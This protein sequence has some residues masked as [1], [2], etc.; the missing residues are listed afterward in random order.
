VD[1]WPEIVRT[2]GPAAYRAAWRILGQQQDCEDV[3]QEAFVEAFTKFET[4]EVVHWQSFLNRLVTFRAIDSMR[5]RRRTDNVHEN[6]VLDPAPGP[7]ATVIDGEQD[8]IFRQCVAALPDRQAAV[9]CMVHFEGVS[10]QQIAE[11]LEITTGAVAMALHKARANLQQK[12]IPKLE[13]S[14]ND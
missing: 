11:T 1:R 7:E 8:A 12:L 14:G 4:N 13:E 6:P 10:H 2:H 5:R 9:F 3:V